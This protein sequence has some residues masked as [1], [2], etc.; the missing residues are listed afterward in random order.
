[1]RH[2]S[3]LAPA[4]PMHVRPILLALREK[5]GVLNTLLVHYARGALA[6][7]PRHINGHTHT[8]L[9]HTTDCLLTTAP[10]SLSLYL[11]AM[12]TQPSQGARLCPVVAKLGLRLRQGVRTSRLEAAQYAVRSTTVQTVL[13]THSSH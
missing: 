7:V 2:L 6:Q 1:M 5:V 9:Y 12:W 11:P 3:L 8:L 10:F 13:F 4:W